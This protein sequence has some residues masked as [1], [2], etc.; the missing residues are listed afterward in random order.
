M[1]ARRPGTTTLQRM[2]L[3][4][5]HTYA[6]EP[7][8]VA[9]LLRT[10]AFLDDVATHAGA[11]SHSVE[12]RD[13]ATVLG[14]KLPVPSHLTKFV[15]Q[16]V[17]LTQTFRFQAPGADGAVRGTVDVDVPGMPVEVQADALLSPV[18]EGTRARYTGDLKVRIPL[19]GKKVETQLEPFIRDAFEGLER[20]AAD[21]LSR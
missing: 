3:D 21:W 9:S 10:E 7:A 6:A 16:A 4:Y 19:V 15:G 8:R 20:R 13:D 18:P 17:Q 14:M 12:L 5:T 1:L 11:V 2:Q